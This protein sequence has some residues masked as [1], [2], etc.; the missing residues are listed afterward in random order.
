MS[1]TPVREARNPHAFA[2]DLERIVGEM[3]GAQRR[4]DQ[5]AYLTLDT[6]YHAAFSEHCGNPYLRDSYESYA[7]KI[8]ALRTRRRQ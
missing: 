6:S 1:K 7:G 3:A 8:A 2:V 5:R 4:G